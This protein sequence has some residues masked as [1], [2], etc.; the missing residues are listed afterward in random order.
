MHVE[1]PD[2]VRVDESELLASPDAVPGEHCDWASMH[3]STQLTIQNE[4]MF[5]VGGIV[6][7]DEKYQY[8]YYVGAGVYIREV[9]EMQESL[10]W[11][12]HD[13]EADAN[14]IDE[15]SDGKYSLES[16]IKALARTMLTDGYTHGLRMAESEDDIR[17]EYAEKELNEEYVVQIFWDQ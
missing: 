12:E 1:I 15:T 13:F 4:S 9:R 3:S 5:D 10:D 11:L 16:R 2:P 8:D 7:L 6:F 14:G 17:I